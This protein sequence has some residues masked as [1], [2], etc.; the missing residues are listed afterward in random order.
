[1]PTS[2]M[3]FDCGLAN[4]CS[5]G[6]QEEPN[7]NDHVSSPLFLCDDLC[8]CGYSC[9]RLDGH[10]GSHEAGIDIRTKVVARWNGIVQKVDNLNLRRAL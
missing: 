1:M 4:D 5:F 10:L 7:F 6:S 9:T 3:C 2:Y 8:P